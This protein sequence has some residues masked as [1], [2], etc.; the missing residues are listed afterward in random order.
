V[1]VDGLDVLGDGADSGYAGHV[2]VVFGREPPHRHC[3]TTLGSS[4]APV[5][6]RG[7]VMRGCCTIV[8]T[9]W[10][11]SRRRAIRRATGAGYAA[12]PRTRQY[13]R[14][15]HPVA[16]D[17]TWPDRIAADAGDQPVTAAGAIATFWP[18]RPTHPRPRSLT[19]WVLIDWDQTCLGPR[20]LG[21]L[22]DL[23]DHFHEPSTDRRKFPTAYS[24]NILDWPDWTLLR[25]LTEL[26]SLGAYIRLAPSKPAATTE[27]RHRLHSLRTGDASAQWH[28]TPWPSTREPPSDNED[29][30]PRVVFA[31]GVGEVAVLAGGDHGVA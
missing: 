21:L 17:P 11:C 23:P 5:L 24:Y 13:R 12:A 8:P 19:W 28:A 4:G 9:R 7:S 25:D 20:E 29:E 26:H 31:V 16:D 27:L 15:R 1:T 6:S 22:T 14:R 3:S 10:T 18:Y 30:P 2:V